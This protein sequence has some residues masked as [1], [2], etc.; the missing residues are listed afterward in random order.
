MVTVLLFVM[1]YV[2]SAVDA[3]ASGTVPDQLEA[4]PQLPA[5]STFQ[6]AAPTGPETITAVAIQITPWIFRDPDFLMVL[7][8]FNPVVRSWTGSLKAGWLFFIRVA[9]RTD[10]SKHHQRPMAFDMPDG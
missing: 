3:A 9:G 1:L 6:V 5:L 7:L 2:N 4:V 10:D 8:R